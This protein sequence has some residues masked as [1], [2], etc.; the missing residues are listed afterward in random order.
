MF[1]KSDDDKIFVNWNERQNK[2]QNQVKI[3]PNR[4]KKSINLK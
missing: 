3:Q 4:Q 2:S 1:N